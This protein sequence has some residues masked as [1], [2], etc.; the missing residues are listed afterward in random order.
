MDLN[1]SLEYLL[2]NPSVALGHVDRLTITFPVL[3]LYSDSPSS[4]SHRIIPS[5]IVLTLVCLFFL[6]V[7]SHSLRYV[8]LA[9]V[10]S[11]ILNLE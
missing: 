2:G 3:L 10:P 8:C 6:S 11:L 7:C 4:L 5:R 1:R 9:L